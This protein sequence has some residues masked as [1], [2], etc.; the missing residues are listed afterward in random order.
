[1]MRLYSYLPSLDLHGMDTVIAKLLIEE[2]I[3]DQKKLK[4]KECLII[5][6]IGTG[7]LRKITCETLKHH[8][9]VL[10]AKLDCFNPGCT[11]VKLK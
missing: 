8:P 3:C 6:G 2:F 1:M 5:H 9:L 4:N 10:E 7:A 11:I